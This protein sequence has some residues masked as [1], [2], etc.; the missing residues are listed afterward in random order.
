MDFVCVVRVGGD[1][2][3]MPRA[4]VSS[5]LNGMMNQIPKDKE[6]VVKER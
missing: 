6:I 3:L 5:V 2:P 4:R 1:V